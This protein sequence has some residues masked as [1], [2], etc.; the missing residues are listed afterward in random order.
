MSVDGQLTSAAPQ[1]LLSS[2]CPGS[3]SALEGWTAGTAV[4]LVDRSLSAALGRGWPFVPLGEHVDHPPPVE[5][6][7]QQKNTKSPQ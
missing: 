6:P 3:G 1:D 5:R 4:Q 7:V 2:C